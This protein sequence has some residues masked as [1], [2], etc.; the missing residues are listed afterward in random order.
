MSE[1][2]AQ[3]A[4]SAG[5][6]PR[7]ILKKYKIKEV[8]FYFTFDGNKYYLENKEYK[9]ENFY[10]YMKN[11]PEQI[12][13][14]AAPNVNDWLEA[15]EEFYRE[16]YRKFIVTTISPKLSA[17]FQNANMA[18]IAYMK[19]KKDAKIEVVTSNS[20][21][22]GQA[23][24][25][26]KIAQLINE[27]V[28]SWEEFLPKINI[29]V[30]GLTTLFSVHNLIYMKAGGRIGGATAFLGKLI[31]IKP[32]CEFVNGAVRPIKAVRGRKKALTVLVDTVIERIKD[33]NNV[34]ICTQSALSEDDEDF[35]IQRIRRSL[36]YQGEIYRGTLGTT[37]GAHSGPGSIGIGFVE[38]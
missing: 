12:P 29:M 19:S 26:I 1:K 9:T 8:P 35:I 3:L 2:I 21:T 28:M 16:G 31:N 30:S 17:S 14:T 20:C 11:N 7:E 18:R 6:L 24:L 34:V 23:A 5:N 10:K 36:D 37:I 22:C 32:I 15:F 13:K 33:I 25:E 38:G 4:D 27:G